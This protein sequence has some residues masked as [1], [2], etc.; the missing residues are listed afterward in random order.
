MFI[1]DDILMAVRAG[2]VGVMLAGAAA[3][4]SLGFAACEVYEHTVPWGLGPQLQR[5]SD[6]IPG[7]MEGARSQGRQEQFAADELT[8]SGPGGWSERLSA[9]TQEKSQISTDA[10]TYLSR[11][12]STGQASRTAAYELGRRSCNAPTGDSGTGPGSSGAAPGGMLDDD[13]ELRSVLSGAA[14]APT[15]H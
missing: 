9:C 2:K 4:A 11:V 13:T 14:Y 15:P 10:S 6:S 3:S 5:L 7:K 12:L 1:I 8:I